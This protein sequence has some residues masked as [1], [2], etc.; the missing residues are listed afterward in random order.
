MTPETL[1]ILKSSQDAREI[2]L[3]AAQVAAGTDARDLDTLYTFLTDPAFL[4]RLDD[5]AA[6]Q[7]TYSDL[8]LGAVLQAL[9]DNRIQASDQLLLKLTRSDA[10][11][12]EVLRMQLL[13]RA[14][15]PL[16]PSPPPAI[17]FWESMSLP[18]S[19]IAF[20]VVEALATNQSPPAMDLL[21]KKFTDA[22]EVPP[23][24][25]VWMRQILLP[26]RNDEPLL[27]V[28][29]KL[30][31]AGQPA[32]AHIELVEALFDYKPKSWYRRCEPPVPP[33]RI[34]ATPA[35]K[36]IIRRIAEYALANMQLPPELEAS[37]KIGLQEVGGAK[38]N[39]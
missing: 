12:Q 16:K 8:R 20:D 21:E 27:I 10:F 36:E 26:R 38:N 30:V 31:K 18:Q 13:I 9:M 3:A 11:L 17:A 24:K 2:K 6:Y 25:I 14:L 37:V 35:A 23:E 34:L 32:G 7:G 4:L 5:A 33:K 19:P 28:W 22:R 1:N 29:E 15:V 39:P